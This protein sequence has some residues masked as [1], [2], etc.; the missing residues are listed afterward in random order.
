MTTKGTA[1]G[2]VACAAGMAAYS[3]SVYS[4]LP[5]SVPSHWNIQGQVDGWMPRDMA[6]VTKLLM[7]NRLIVLLVSLAA[8]LSTSAAVNAAPPPASDKATAL[9]WID[10]PDA[11]LE[12]RGL[13]WLK[14]NAPRTHRMILEGERDGRLTKDHI[15][16]D[17]TSG[18]TGI[19]YAMI[20][21]IK[22]YRLKLCLP[23]NASHE[24]KQILK[25]LESAKLEAEMATIA[26]SRFLATAS[27]DLRQPLQALALL[28][29][30][31]LEPT[32][33]E[34]IKHLLEVA[35][36]ALKQE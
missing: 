27:H 7:R 6:V 19:A 23:A 33:I 25:A 35:V 31:T 10:W 29:V 20:C 14:E 28:Q 26:K 32:D 22:G 17:A 15:L 34:S 4:A 1:L 36:V 3:A 13:P 21:A 24:R 2:I 8:S 18:N 30:Q 11:R 5:K 16:L 9:K 12:M